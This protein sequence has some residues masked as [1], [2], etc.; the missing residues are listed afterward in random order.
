[1]RKVA[2]LNLFLFL[3]LSGCKEEDTVT[4]SQTL[5]LYLNDT[6][7]PVKI[8]GRS[9][10][11][12]YYT[13][14]EIRCIDISGSVTEGVDSTLINILNISFTIVSPKIKDTLT[15]A[16]ANYSSTYNG[17]KGF[18]ESGI[19]IHYKSYSTF[20]KSINGYV[21]LEELTDNFVKGYLEFNL[22]HNSDT[23]NTVHLKGYF[24]SIL[25]YY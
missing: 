11:R 5:N 18:I 20:D 16:D 1:V 8:S 14:A 24:D 15:T 2:W 7:I 9:Y 17:A 6:L 19:D 22:K 21:I 25:K 13:S 10:T 3:I 23:L 4:S 12:P